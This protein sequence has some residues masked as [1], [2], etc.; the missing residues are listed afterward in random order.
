MCVVSVGERVCRGFLSYL[1]RCLS[2]KCVK[3]HVPGNR[4]FID[5]T[6]LYGA[7]IEC[8]YKLMIFQLILF[9]LCTILRAEFLLASNLKT[10]AYFYFLQ[11]ALNYLHPPEQGWNG[12]TAYQMWVHKIVNILNISSTSKNTA[13]SD[14]CSYSFLIIS[15]Q[16]I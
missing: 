6:G 8:T 2:S 15:R 11:D 14:K 12:T 1:R 7:E 3:Y 10:F 9:S 16:D 13:Q 4:S 5:P